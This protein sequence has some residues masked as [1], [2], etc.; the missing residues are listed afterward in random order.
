[1]QLDH[2]STDNE[3]AILPNVRIDISGSGGGTLR[4]LNVNMWGLKLPLAMDRRERF[5]ALRNHLRRNYYDVVLLQE[6]WDRASYDILRQSKLYITPFKAFNGC[7]GRLPLPLECS[8]LV[9][10]SRHPIKK[11]WYKE[12]SVR[13]NVIPPD[14]QGQL[15]V[16]KG[17]AVARIWWN[18][19][20]VDVFTSHLVSYMMS[21]RENR[22]IRKTQ[23][24]EAVDFIRKSSADVQIFAGDANA[25]PKSPTYRI[26]T[27]AMRDPLIERFGPRSSLDPRWRTWGN[28]RNTYTAG[29]PGAARI[30]YLLY[31][32]RPG[33]QIYPTHFNLPPLRAYAAGSKVSITDHEPILAEFSIRKAGPV[34]GYYGR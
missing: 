20:N 16:R 8:G 28:R 5:V 27:S 11:H 19:L 4:V 14:P 32:G 1:M 24:K 33:V 22:N 6:V 7:S 12:F 15:F 25:T 30:D 23:A 17:L 26:L 9:I 2:K 31:R 10:L 3:F 29:M 21:D 18:G 34:T 13:G